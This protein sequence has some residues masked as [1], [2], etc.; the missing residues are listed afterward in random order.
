M[1]WFSKEPVRGIEIVKMVKYKI[2]ASCPIMIKGSST[3]CPPIQV[4]IKVL[5]TRAQKQILAMGE[6]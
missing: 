2:E 3:G 5:A 1:R 4:R 6:M